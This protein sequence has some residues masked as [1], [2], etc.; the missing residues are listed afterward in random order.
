ML[1]IEYEIK[2]NDEGRPCI[3]L[4][5][6]YENKSED[7]FFVIE[8]SRYMLQNVYNRR[9]KEFDAEAANALDVTIRLLGQVGDEIAALIYGQMVSMG[10]FELAMN[11]SCHIQV[12]TIEERDA[13]PETGFFYEGKIFNRQEG[14]KVLILSYEPDQP[15]PLSSIY[16]LQGGITNDNWIK[17]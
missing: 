11:S 14:L 17:L 1:K 5:K 13:I 16:V 9:S 8:L 10:E 15:L 12:S 3:D 2:L 7:K 4:S 6:D